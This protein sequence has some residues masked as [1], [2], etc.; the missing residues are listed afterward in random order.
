MTLAL[1]MSCY[2]INNKHCFI[3]TLEFTILPTS[4]YDQC[5]VMSNMIQSAYSKVLIIYWKTG[6]QANSAASS[7]ISS[8]GDISCGVL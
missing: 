1:L 2:Y 8:E 3:L 4:R 5:L 7:Q 6:K